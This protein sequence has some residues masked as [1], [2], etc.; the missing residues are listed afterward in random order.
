[1]MIEENKNTPGSYWITYLAVA[2]TVALLLLLCHLIHLDRWL[3]SLASGILSWVW[4]LVE[5]LWTTND[6]EHRLVGLFDL[7][8]EET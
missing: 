7:Q 6:A 3:G 4:V 8:V 2:A 5:S 1:M